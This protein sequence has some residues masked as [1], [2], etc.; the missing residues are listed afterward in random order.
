[1]G[2]REEHR[3]VGAYVPSAALGVQFAALCALITAVLLLSARLTGVDSFADWHRWTHLFLLTLT[4]VGVVVG[5]RVHPLMAVAFAGQSLAQAMA[6]FRPMPA[7]WSASL[8]LADLGQVVWGV[9]LAMLLLSHLRRTGQL[10]ALVHVLDAAMVTLA[11]VFVLWEL[12]IAPALGDT[13]RLSTLQQV[14]VVLSPALDLYV[15]AILL[16][17]LLVDRSAGRYVWFG[18]MVCLVVGDVAESRMG[19]LPTTTSLVVATSAWAVG[20]TGVVAML[21]LP[22]KPSVI[23]RRPRMG[24]LVVVNVVVGVALWVAAREYM[25]RGGRAGVASVVIGVVAGFVF[26]ASQ[27]ASFRQSSDWAQQ[28]HRNLGELETAHE[29]LRELLDDLPEAVVVL[30]SD[31]RILETNDRMR[32]LSGS[33]DGDLYGRPFTSLFRR[34]DRGQ[35]RTMWESVMRG[36]GMTPPFLTFDSASGT[37]VVLEADANVPVRNPE[38]VVVALRDVTPRITESRRL[39]LARERFRLAFH[40]APTGMALSSMRDGRLIDVNESLVRMLGRPRH[41]LLAS[42]IDDISHPDERGVSAPL[43]GRVS[44]AEGDGFRV[45]RRFLRGDGGIVWARTWVSIMDDGDGDTLAIAHIEDVTEQRRTA[46]RMEWAATHDMLTGLPNRFRFLERLSTF[47]DSDDRGTIAVLFVDIDN[48]K[49]INDSLGH[50]AG[51]Q[52]LRALSERLRSVVRDR[53]M[54]GRFGGDEFIVMLRDLNGTLDP[55]SI[56]E[57]LRAEI[58]RPIEVDGAEL[59]VTASIGITVADRDGIT[60]SEMLRDAD[61]A[62]YRAKARGRDCV[63]VFSP[64]THD[65]SMLNLRTTNELRRGIE[66]GEIIPYYQP[67]INLGSGELVGFEVLARWRHPDRGLLGADKFLPMAEETGLIG[68]VGAAVLRASLVQLGE[69]QQHS[70]RLDQLSLSVN[71][72]ARQ[73]T[74][75]RLVDLVEEALGQAGVQAGSLWLEITETALMADVKAATVA[76][77][78]LRSLGLHLAVDDF[79][80]GYSSL[81]YLKRF[82]VE[83]IKVD[84]SFVSGL[85]ID[86]E[87]S[88][89]V[90]AVVKLGHS[91]NLQVVAEGVETPLQLTRLRELGCDRAQGFLFGRPRPA[92]LVEAEY[93]LVGQ[94]A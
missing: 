86:A 75:G 44:T 5:S 80:T 19:G 62:M 17:L 33:G 56:A 16:L 39:E 57:R 26:M 20:F 34:S 7:A 76:L 64:G 1:V 71:L 4:L 22:P 90:D 37:E 55:V 60:T 46:E 27:V 8:S 11:G 78:D 93:S 24:R 40:N 9:S 81:T 65:A 41:E 59:F 29:Q 31:G 30:S 49:V 2:M 13:S 47:I 84:R 25:L 14:M 38:R 12:V 72:S 42:T 68:E 21:G 82:P 10:A 77:R 6:A 35:L 70:P 85:G 69:W 63:E 58:A 32:S 23:Q 15:A 67:I 18:A 88:T 54:L 43:L 45:E 52:L 28:L 91:L 66:R 50:D 73:L 92:D 74:D 89:I 61:A 53:D 83:A 48:F 3:D 79:G 51:D 87:D 94:R 36:Q